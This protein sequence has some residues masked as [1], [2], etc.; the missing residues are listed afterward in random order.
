MSIIMDEIRNK[1]TIHTM[2][3]ARLKQWRTK[4]GV[5]GVRTPSFWRVI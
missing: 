4:E 3:L 5:K 1:P 2:G